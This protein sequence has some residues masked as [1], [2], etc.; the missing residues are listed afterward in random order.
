[1]REIYERHREAVNTYDLDRVAEFV[2]PDVAFEWD[3][4]DFYRLA[5]WHFDERIGETDLGRR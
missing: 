1:M 5:W 2:A 3:C 4:V